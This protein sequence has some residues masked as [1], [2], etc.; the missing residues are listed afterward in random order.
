MAPN[1]GSFF[2][3]K[4]RNGYTED[5]SRIIV[6]DGCISKIRTPGKKQ[7]REKRWHSTL[8]LYLRVNKRV[9]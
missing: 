2:S 5:I 3:N 9:K 6:D 7:V 4:K 1:T 8:D